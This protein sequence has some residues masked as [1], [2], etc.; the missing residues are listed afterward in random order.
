[1][2]KLKV[3]VSDLTKVTKKVE[4]GI[5]TEF[6]FGHLRTPSYGF[7][8]SF[9]D[10]AEIKKFV[11]FTERYDSITLGTGIENGVVW[12]EALTF[13]DMNEIG[14]TS[15]PKIRKQLQLNGGFLSE[16]RMQTF[17]E[18]EHGN[19]SGYFVFTNYIYLKNEAGESIE[20]GK[21]Y[22]EGSTIDNNGNRCIFC[23]VQSAT[24][25]LFITGCAA[26]MCAPSAI[27]IV[28]LSGVDDPN[29]TLEEC[30]F[31]GRG[32]SGSLIAKNNLMEIQASDMCALDD[33]LMLRFAKDFYNRAKNWH[34]VSWIPYL[35]ECIEVIDRCILERDYKLIHG[36]LRFDRHLAYRCK[37]GTRDFPIDEPFSNLYHLVSFSFPMIYLLTTISDIISHIVFITNRCK[38]RSFGVFLQQPSENAK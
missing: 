38:P 23:P 11:L 14:F 12:C 20:I 13:G 7:P 19:T 8:V 24:G 31:H 28:D 32:E 15:K 2:S 4:S 1:M 37:A 6:C 16:I 17:A 34:L 10:N 36:V 5:A 30:V 35:P 25:T 29:G 9:T 3:N 26:H 33:E 27:Q 22:D 21:Q 18:G